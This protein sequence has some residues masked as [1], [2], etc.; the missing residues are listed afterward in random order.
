MDPVHYHKIEELFIS[1]YNG[2]MAYALSVLKN[3][4][5]AEEAVQETF[6]VACVKPEALCASPNPRGWLVNTLKLTIAG[7]KKN[8]ATAAQ[9]LTD[10]ATAQ[11]NED[12]AVSED[13]Y[14][15]DLLYGDI[16]QTEEYRL[17]KEMA[18][19]GRSHLEMAQSRG[20]SVDACKKR[21]QRAREFLR[22]KLR[23][24]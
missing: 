22:S 4:S 19:E 12:Q 16:A 14:N 6:R 8:R 18:I 10:Y 24:G 3:E 17:I 15:F 5:L 11:I 7:M 20:I 2:L 9:L 23:T 21:V 1:M 13:L